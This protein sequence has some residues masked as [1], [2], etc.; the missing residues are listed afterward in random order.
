MFGSGLDCLS[1]SG[2]VVTCS[3]CTYNRAGATCCV[4]CGVAL[5]APQSLTSERMGSGETGWHSRSWQHT[6][7]VN[8]HCHAIALVFDIIV[9]RFGSYILH[10][11]RARLLLCGC[12]MCSALIIHIN[13]N[14]QK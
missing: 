13:I 8:S 14:M 1:A 10:K 4:R 2:V 7:V 11:Y 12:V 3:A 6:V 9:Q 5:H